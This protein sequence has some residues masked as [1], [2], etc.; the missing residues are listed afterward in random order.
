MSALEKC[1]EQIRGFESLPIVRLT[2]GIIH[3]QRES[4]V[5]EME[6]SYMLPDVA[7]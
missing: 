2:D 7:D 3:G 5:L 6:P 4:G 1:I